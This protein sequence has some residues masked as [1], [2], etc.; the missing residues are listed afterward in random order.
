MYIYGTT[1]LIKQPCLRKISG[2][3]VWYQYNKLDINVVV[4]NNIIPRLDFPHMVS[5][6]RL[7]CPRQRLTPKR[8]FRV[9]VNGWR[10]RE[11]DVS[12]STV[13]VQGRLA[14]PRQRLTRKGGILIVYACCSQASKLPILQCFIGPMKIW[15][16]MCNQYKRNI[17]RN[18]YFLT[19]RGQC[20][21]VG[22]CGWGSWLG[23]LILTGEQ[24]LLG[25]AC[26]L[27][28][29]YQAIIM[30]TQFLFKSNI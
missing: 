23:R 14:C 3:L 19:G 16:I 28:T 7:A 29:C 25:L 11:G 6:W 4:F 21:C 20:V 15:W 26:Q 8:A 12:T 5:E 2:S 18:F 9:H 27:I 13:D 17:K 30:W 22:G 24:I 1:A 10:A